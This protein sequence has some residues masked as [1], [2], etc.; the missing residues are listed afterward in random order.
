[1]ARVSRMLDMQRQSLGTYDKCRPHAQADSMQPAWQQM[2]S[3][4][5][6]DHSNR[7]GVIRLLI[8]RGTRRDVR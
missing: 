3:V 6:G 4:V 1:M 2:N 7:C 5:P 8:A